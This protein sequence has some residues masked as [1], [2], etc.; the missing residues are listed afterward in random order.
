MKM[1]GAMKKIRSTSAEAAEL[2]RRAEDR[3]KA[4]IP[5][6]TASL[7]AADTQRLFH[8]LQVHQIKLETQSEELLQWRAGAEA[9]AEVLHRTL[10][11]CPWGLLDRP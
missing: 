4:A 8:E 9:G 3:V 2:R 5:K 10:R 11:F 7:T 1:R 6:G